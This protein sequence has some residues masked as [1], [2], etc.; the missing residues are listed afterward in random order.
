MEIGMLRSSGYV[1]TILI[2]AMLAIACSDA[3]L[4]SGGLYYHMETERARNAIWTRD[5]DR[6]EE[7]LQSLI[8]EFP[9]RPEAYHLLALSWDA[10]GLTREGEIVDRGMIA[11][12][13]EPMRRAIELAPENVEY[14]LQYAAFLYDTRDFQESVETFRPILREDWDKLDEGLPEGF[15]NTAAYFYT[16]ALIANS[17]Y[18]EAERIAL[19]GIEFW[20]WDEGHPELYV[21]A[22]AHREPDRALRIIEEVE[23]ERGYISSQYLRNAYCVGLQRLERREDARVCYQELLDH[24]GTDPELA[25]N[26]RQRLAE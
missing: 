7:I 2:A 5:F 14:R 20:G 15:L 13:L 25:D 19:K 22:I 17:E 12:A 16:R 1:V 3:P 11:K 10:R 9:Q 21:G 4:E 18:E 24:P 6:A 26:I 23:G 8:D